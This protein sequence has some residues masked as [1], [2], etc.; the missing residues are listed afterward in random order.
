MRARSMGAKRDCARLGLATAAVLA[1]TL[2]A[3]GPA[4]AEERASHAQPGAAT[5]VAAVQQI[6]PTRIDLSRATG[7]AQR[8]LEEAVQHSGSDSSQVIDDI[9]GEAT[10]SVTV[11]ANFPDPGTWDGFRR[12]VADA[13]TSSCFAPDALSHEGFAVQG[14]L[15]L[16]FLVRAASDGACR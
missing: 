7:K 2:A 15:R 11:N 8:H 12:S 3:L 1:A 16:P 4:Q 13:A 6:D 9:A 14:L 5:L 10:G